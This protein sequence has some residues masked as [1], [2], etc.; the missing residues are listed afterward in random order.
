MTTEQEELKAR[1]LKEAEAVIERM[2]ADKRPAGEN[3]LSELERLVVKGGQA[4]EERVI[5]MLVEEESEVES[6]PVC[7]SCGVGMRSRGQRKRAVVTEGGEVRVERRY[8][9]CPRCGGKI[10]PPG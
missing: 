3:S 1:M 9:V 8:Y 5:Q 2:L 10:F 7:E 6:Q 4:F